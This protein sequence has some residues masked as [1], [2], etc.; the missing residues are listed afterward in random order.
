MGEIGIICNYQ[1]FMHWEG[2]VSPLMKTVRII[3]QDKEL[4]SLGDGKQLYE[5]LEAVLNN[6]FSARKYNL[7]D[8]VYLGGQK[9]EVAE[10]HSDW[11]G[12]HGN[13]DSGFDY[14]RVNI[15]NVKPVIRCNP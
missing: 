10:A 5:K 2:G 3:M 4:S 1:N 9:L 7:G 8:I 15:K 11:V 12:L 6:S 14:I 13:I